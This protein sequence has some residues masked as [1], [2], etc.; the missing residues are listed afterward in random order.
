MLTPCAT[1]PAAM[2]GGGYGGGGYSGYGGGGYSGGRYSG[3]GGG[4]SP[5]PSQ[6]GGSSS[7]TG[8]GCPP[9]SAMGP[10]LDRLGSLRAFL[11]HSAVTEHEQAGAG[12]NGSGGGGGGVGVTLSTIHGAKGREWAKVVVVRVNED[13]MPLASPFD[14]EEGSHDGEHLR[15]ERRL[16]Y[17]AMTRAKER[18]V[19]THVMHGP[20]KVPTP[21]SRYPGLSHY[22]TGGRAIAT[23]NKTNKTKPSSTTQ[24]G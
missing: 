7:G 24:R 3:Y 5:S 4:A 11:E 22:P 18:L 9:S 14:D 15:E 12:G 17:V 6:W 8:G 21:A 10:P 19:L 13:V 1:T 20:D 16:L 23:Q 2:S